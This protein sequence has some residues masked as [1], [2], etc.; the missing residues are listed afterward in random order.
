M[1]IN[2]DGLYKAF[3][4]YNLDQDKNEDGPITNIKENLEVNIR[5]SD[6]TFNYMTLNDVTYI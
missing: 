4:D 5:N 2:T 3:F 6:G 1:T